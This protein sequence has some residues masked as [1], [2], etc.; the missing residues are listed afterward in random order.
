MTVDL[1][2]NIELVKV[3]MNYKDNVTRINEGNEWLAALMSGE[4]FKKGKQPKKKIDGIASSA[5]RRAIGK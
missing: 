1:R 3:L 4:A 5:Q 2:E